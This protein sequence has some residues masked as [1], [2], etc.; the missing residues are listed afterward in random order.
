MTSIV[1]NEKSNH[2]FVNMHNYKMSVWRARSSFSSADVSQKK[3]SLSYS[4]VTTWNNLSGII[5]K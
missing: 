1:R 5:G 4:A 3:K 2:K